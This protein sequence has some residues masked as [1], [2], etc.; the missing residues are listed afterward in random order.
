M[1][2]RNKT[3]LVQLIKP[4]RFT[5]TDYLLLTKPFLMNIHVIFIT[6]IIKWTYF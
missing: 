2:L 1:H 3:V 6:Y 4:R 5:V